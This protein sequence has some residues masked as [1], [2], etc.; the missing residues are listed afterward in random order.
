MAWALEEAGASYEVVRLAMEETHGEEHRRRHPLGRVPVLEADEDFLF[1]SAALCLQVADSFP[2]SG[3]IAAPGSHERALAY[4]WT[5]FAMTELEPAVIEAY[6]NRESDPERSQAAMERFLLAAGA[7]DDALDGRDYLI[8]EDFTVADLIVASVLAISRRFDDPELL[9][10][11]AG[12]HLARM[13][14]RPAR[15]RAYAAF[16]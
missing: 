14:E 9:P 7:V 11:R 3:L 6:R 16:A 15:V 13:E 10:P 4:Q 12:A 5:L 2:Q 8:G 1:E